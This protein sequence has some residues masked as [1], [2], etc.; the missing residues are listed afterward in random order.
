MYDARGGSSGSSDSNTVF[1]IAIVGV[2]VAAFAV[3][4]MWPSSSSDKSIIPQVA[5]KSEQVEI[6]AS[7]TGKEERAVI[8]AISD[9]DPD[10]YQRIETRLAS[11]NINTAKRDEIVLQEFSTIVMANIDVIGN[12]DVKHFDAILSDVRTS[13]QKAS[14]SGSKLCKGSTYAKFESMQQSQVTKF[15]QK[16][17]MNNDGVRKFG[18]QTTHRVLE[19]ISDAR[20]NPV[21]HGAMDASDD[22]AIQGLVMS[23][24]TQP[25][26]MSLAMAANT[27]AGAEDAL[28][29]TNICQLSVAALKAVDTLPDRTKGRVWAAAFDAV[30][31]QGGLDRTW[32]SHQS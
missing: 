9:I 28:E 32:L 11:G 3:V 4:L 6:H 23:L 5:E 15:M 31:K 16:E 7:F 26:I 8:A 30:Q 17:L 25:E 24:V 29:K 10:A 27:G 22:S 1:A 12:A 14:R 19:A 21:Q 18:L 20:A 13:L 2:I